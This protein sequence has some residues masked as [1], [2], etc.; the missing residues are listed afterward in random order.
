MAQVDT[1]GS[2]A[3]SALAG[4]YFRSMIGAFRAK[5]RAAGTGHQKKT[6]PRRFSFRRAPPPTT[7]HRCLAIHLLVAERSSALD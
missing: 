3:M 1:K 2:I 5:P 6:A 4:V 7:F